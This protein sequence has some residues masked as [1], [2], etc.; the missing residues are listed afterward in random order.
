[1]KGPSLLRGTGVFDRL[2]ALVARGMDAGVRWQLARLPIELPVPESWTP[3]DPQEFWA[4][5]RVHDPAPITAGPV[6]H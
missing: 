3:A 4:A 2:G 5:S 6:Q 1:M